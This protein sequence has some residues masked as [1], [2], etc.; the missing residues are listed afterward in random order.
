MAKQAV[1]LGARAHRPRLS[2]AP[3]AV[4]GCISRKSAVFHDDPGALTLPGVKPDRL[5][6]TDV[7]C[8]F[9]AAMRVL[10]ERESFR[11]HSVPYKSARGRADNQQCN[12]LLPV[13][14][15]NIVQKVPLAKGAISDWRFPE[16]FVHS[17]AW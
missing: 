8:F 17:A 4:Q 12:S 1:A 10:L 5:P 13:H 11:A 16:A 3:A 15:L 6:G 9:A 7:P 14:K 2:G